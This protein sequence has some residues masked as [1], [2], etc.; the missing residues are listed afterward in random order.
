MG[1]GRKLMS[2]HEMSWMSI[3]ALRPGVNLRPVSRSLLFE[4][5]PLLRR[6]LTIES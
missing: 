6:L 2:V 3:Y 4:M 5:S 1:T